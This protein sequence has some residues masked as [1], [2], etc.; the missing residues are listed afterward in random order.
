MLNKK[1]FSIAT[2]LAGGFGEE[3]CVFRGISAVSLSFSGKSIFSCLLLSCFFLVCC[4]HTVLLRLVTVIPCIFIYVCCVVRFRFKIM[5]CGCWCSRCVL[6]HFHLGRSTWLCWSWSWPAA[7]DCPWCSRWAPEWPWP[8]HRSWSSKRSRS[9]CTDSLWDPWQSLPIAQLQMDQTAA[10]GQP[11]PFP[12]PSCRWKWDT[13]RQ[14]TGQRCGRRR[15][16]S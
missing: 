7:P 4:T 9:P 6:V 3:I 14:A 1:N 8:P 15:R 13:R 5:G 10:T 11:P 16:R 2:L 12:A